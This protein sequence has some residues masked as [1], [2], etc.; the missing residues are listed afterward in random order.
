M[1][2]RLE[3]NEDDPPKKLPR[4]ERENRVEAVKSRLPGAR[5]NDEREPGPSVVNAFVQMGDDGYLQYLP[6][7]KTISAKLEAAEGKVFREWRPNKQ[8]VIS[9]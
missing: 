2:S 6:W 9:E 1:R 8:G 7:H 5:I 3:R 4:V